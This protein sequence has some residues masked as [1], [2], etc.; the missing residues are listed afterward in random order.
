MS[1]I[2]CSDEARIE[3]VMWRKAYQ[4]TRYSVI[5]VSFRLNSLPEVK[6]VD[7]RL[8]ET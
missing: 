4:E 7:N 1:S 5:D 3:R 8:S 6:N 2:N